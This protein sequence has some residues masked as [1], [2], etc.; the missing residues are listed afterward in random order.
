MEKPKPIEPELKRLVKKKKF[1]VAEILAKEH[2]K[3]DF[4]MSILS[5]N[6]YYKTGFKILKKN[7]MDYYKYPGLMGR[8]QKCYVRYLLKNF[9]WVRTVLHKSN[10][11]AQ[12]KL[13]SR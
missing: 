6:K 5:T 1:D 7:G 9:E 8:A 10:I 12:S 11:M 2:G 4:L 3:F 13:E